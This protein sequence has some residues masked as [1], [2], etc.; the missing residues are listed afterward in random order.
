MESL[1]IQAQ[2]QIRADRM[3]LV[4]NRVR[5]QIY[6][7]VWY[8][9]WVQIPSLNLVRDQIWDQVLIGLKK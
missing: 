2:Y 1:K 3:K 8:Q 9:I 5:D 4:K 7:Q 6:D